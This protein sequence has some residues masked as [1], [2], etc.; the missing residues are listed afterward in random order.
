MGCANVFVMEIVPLILALLCTGGLAYLFYRRGWHK[1]RFF[2]DP[3]IR[4]WV[5]LSWMVLEIWSAITLGDWYFWVF[6]LMFAVYA[7]L[8]FF[9]VHKEKART[10][11]A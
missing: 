10:W 6:A 3:R 11:R 4:R 2:T 5:F 8:D 9:L 7:A 1:A